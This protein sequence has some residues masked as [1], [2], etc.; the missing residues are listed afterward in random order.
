MNF[1]TTL[2]RCE[3]FP[4]YYFRPII[5]NDLKAEAQDLQQNHNLYEELSEDIFQSYRK[6]EKEKLKRS[7]NNAFVENL[8]SSSITRIN[9]VFEKVV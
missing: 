2:E 1:S 6:A 4:E 5:E 8:I 7:M 3:E 9:E